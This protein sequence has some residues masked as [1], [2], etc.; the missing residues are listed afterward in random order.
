MS[1]AN[2]KMDARPHTVG[3][4]WDCRRDMWTGWAQAPVKVSADPRYCQSCEN[5]RHHH[6]G[7]D[8]TLARN[9]HAE[10]IPAEWAEDDTTWRRRGNCAGTDEDEIFDPAPDEDERPAGWDPELHAKT[11]QYAADAYCSFCPVVLVCR[12]RAEFHGYE[13]VW[14]GAAFERETWTDLLV[15]GVGGKTIHHHRAPR[16]DRGYLPTVEVVDTPS[17]ENAAA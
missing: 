8:P 13:G 5:W 1:G 16:T 17:E 6:P 9:T 11:Q 14:G 15:P 10:R 12:A 4:C 3:L 2:W 7:G